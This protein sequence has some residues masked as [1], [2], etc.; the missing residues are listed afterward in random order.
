MVP[1]FING[2]QAQ[3]ASI[4]ARFRA[5]GAVEPGRAIAWSPA[6]KLERAQF[7]RLVERGALVEMRPGTWYLNEEKLAATDASRL[8]LTVVG[9]ALVALLGGLI[10]LVKG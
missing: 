9:L 6:G 8:V 3:T 4:P 1:I 2:A 5:E 10:L 7:A